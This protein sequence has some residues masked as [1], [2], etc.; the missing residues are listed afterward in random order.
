ML[1]N[2]CYLVVEPCSSVVLSVR[3]SKDALTA[4]LTFTINFASI[5]AS[6]HLLHIYRHRYDKTMMA[7]LILAFFHF[8][9]WQALPESCLLLQTSEQIALA[10]TSSFLLVAAR[11]FWM[12]SFLKRFL[13]FR[14]IWNHSLVAV[15]TAQVTLRNLQCSKGRLPSHMHPTP[16][17]K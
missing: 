3:K 7:Y 8:S 5:L 15:A 12:A 11:P 16:N 14:F 10:Y 9:L 13:H 6:L 17:Q 2:A 4:C 1:T